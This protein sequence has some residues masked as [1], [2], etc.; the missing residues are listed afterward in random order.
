MKKALTLFASVAIVAMLFTSCKKTHTC[1]CTDSSGTIL[2]PFAKSSKK[3]ATAACNTLNSLWVI[4]GG[5]CK[6]N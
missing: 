2:Y 4:S 1:S 3:D 5:S 6:L